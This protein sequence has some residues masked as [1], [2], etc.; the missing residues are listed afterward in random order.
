MREEYFDE[1]LTIF[2]N[3]NK[4]VIN[5]QIISQRVKFTGMKQ[6]SCGRSPQTTQRKALF[7]SMT[8]ILKFI[9]DEKPPK[10]MPYLHLK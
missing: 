1:Q 4:V 3:R 7:S 9:K 8:I 6:L 2:E 5:E 10:I